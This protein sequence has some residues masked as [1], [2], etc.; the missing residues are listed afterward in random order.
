[1]TTTS[2]HVPLAYSYV[3]MST[4]IQLK[5]H[6]KQRQLETFQ[7]YAKA[8]GLKLADESQLVDIGKSA[9]KGPTSKRV[10]SVSF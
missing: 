7:D 10:P 2:D 8:N 1:M 3:R 5:G 9:F 6:S 4:D